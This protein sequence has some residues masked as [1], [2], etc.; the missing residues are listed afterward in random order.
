M[1]SIKLTKS[2]LKNLIRETIESSESGIVK[3]NIVVEIDAEDLLADAGPGV[4]T[5]DV[6]EVLN[7][8]LDY[9]ISSIGLE[10]LLMSE[11]QDVDGTPV[12]VRSVTVS[13][14]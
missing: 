6:K 9:A 7:T 8:K 14:V 11:F 2:M 4:S 10:D 13:G 3:L 1:K 5:E 12:A